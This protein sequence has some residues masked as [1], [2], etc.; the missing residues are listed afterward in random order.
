MYNMIVMIM[1]YLFNV[2]LNNT[3]LHFFRSF[4]AIFPPNKGDKNSMIK[5]GI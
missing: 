1:K 5:V 4:P 2:S 3:F